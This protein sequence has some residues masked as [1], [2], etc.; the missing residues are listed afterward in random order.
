MNSGS[1]NTKV[2]PIPMTRDNLKMIY[3]TSMDDINF[4]PRESDMVLDKDDIGKKVSHGKK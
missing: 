4:K 1:R 3:T 2:P